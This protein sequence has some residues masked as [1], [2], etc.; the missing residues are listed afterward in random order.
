MK[1]KEETYRAIM[2]ILMVLGM[3]LFLIAIILLYKNIEE[4]RNDPIIYGMEKH[5]FSSCTCFT[6]DFQ[7]TTITLGDYQKGDT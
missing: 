5:E 6:D 4:I 3:V 2:M 1:M 7:Y